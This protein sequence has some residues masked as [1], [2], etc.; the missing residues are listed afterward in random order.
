MIKVMKYLLVLVLGL[1]LVGCGTSGK[2]EKVYTI[3]TDKTY[4]PFEM[5]NDKG[6]LIGIDME[7]IRA[8]AKNQKF[9]IQINSLG[10]DA[11]CT[12]LESGEADGVIAGMT[13]NDERKKKYDFSTPYYK[14]GV[15]LGVAKD[16]SIKGYNDLKGKT[17]VAKTSTAGLAFA[18]SIKNK[19]GFK[20]E[21][22]EESS[23]M[24][25][26]VKSHE[27]AAC[28]EDTPV[29]KYMIKTGELNFNIPTPSANPS[30]YG[31]AVSKGMNGELLKK[32]NKGLENL[33]KDGTYDKILHKYE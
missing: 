5:T 24:F 1:S 4:A 6:K 14:T 31:F 10:F 18:Q 3:A 27:A 22:V 23:L 20:L 11:A 16:S 15:S 13:I 7:L 30:F 32:F 8:I 17:V 2:G 28:F 26:K 29:L 12:A 25:E 9:K 33:K 19:Y 21:V